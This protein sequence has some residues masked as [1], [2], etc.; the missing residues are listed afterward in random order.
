MWERGESVRLQAKLGWGCEVS[1]VER[2]GSVRRWAEPGE[3]REAVGHL[4][5]GGAGLSRIIDYSSSS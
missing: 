2:G 4:G 5:P 1:G 3:E